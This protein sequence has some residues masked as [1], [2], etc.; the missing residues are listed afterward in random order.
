MS[1]KKK[2]EVPD[3]NLSLPLRLWGILDFEFVG[4]FVP[5][6]LFPFT[7]YSWYLLLLGVALLVAMAI[8]RVPG[9]QK[10]RRTLR[11]FRPR[12]ILPN[13]L[14]RNRRRRAFFPWPY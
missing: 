10:M 13:R 6:V 7:R 4:F 14:Q 9:R 3:N 12:L 11:V 1:E 5:A 8:L 2:G